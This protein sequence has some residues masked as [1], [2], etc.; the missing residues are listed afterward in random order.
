MYIYMSVERERTM[1]RC[2]ATASKQRINSLVASQVTATLTGTKG[3]SLVV[4][5]SS[6]CTSSK[7]DDK[8]DGVTTTPKTTTNQKKKKEDPSDN[9]KNLLKNFEQ[10][11]DT[12][13]EDQQTTKD[14][15]QQ[16]QQS[17]SSSKEQQLQKTSDKPSLKKISN[18]P[19]FDASFASYNGGGLGMYMAE[20]EADE[21]TAADEEFDI[22][23]FK[24]MRFNEHED[25]IIEDVEDED[26]MIEDYELD[27]DDYGGDIVDDLL[28]ESQAI[29]YE[30]DGEDG[31]GVKLSKGDEADLDEDAD[32]DQDEEFIDEYEED[33]DELDDELLDDADNDGDLIGEE[34]LDKELDKLLSKKDQEFAMAEFDNIQEEE[35]DEPQAEF[36]MQDMDEA[37]EL[38]VERATEDDDEDV[39][40]PQDIAEYLDLE[41]LDRQ[42]LFTHTE[43]LELFMKNFDGE[44]GILETLENEL[45]QDGKQEVDEI[46]QD[47]DDEDDMIQVEEEIDLEEIEEDEE[48]EG[49]EMDDDLEEFDE[50]G[51]EEV[52][53]DNLSDEETDLAVRAESLIKDLPTLPFHEE[54]AIAQ[55]EGLTPFDQR[56]ADYGKLTKDKMRVFTKNWEQGLLQDSLETLFADDMAQLA[57]TQDP[58][59]VP[60]IFDPK[61]IKEYNDDVNEKLGDQF[62]EHHQRLELVQELIDA[63]PEDSPTI[64][65]Y[66]KLEQHQDQDQIALPESAKQKAKLKALLTKYSVEETKAIVQDNIAGNDALDAGLITPQ[67]YLVQPKSQQEINFYNLNTIESTAFE[68][69]AAD[70][71]KVV[72]AVGGVVGGAV[73]GVV[74]T[75]ATEMFV[76][77]SDVI[78]KEDDAKWDA[79]LEAQIVDAMDQTIAQDYKQQEAQEL[80]DQEEHDKYNEI[81]KE[82]TDYEPPNITVDSIFQLSEDNEFYNSPS[83]VKDFG[84][85]EPHTY[86]EM[87]VA[88]VDAHTSQMGIEKDDEEDDEFHDPNAIINTKY[89]YLKKMDLYE[90]E[91]KRDVEN[92]EMQVYDQSAVQADME[93]LT[94]QLDLVISQDIDNIVEEK[95]TP[96][97]VLAA[98]KLGKAKDFEIN[99]NE[100]SSG[101]IEITEENIEQLLAQA[102][103]WNNTSDIDQI[104]REL[105]QEVAGQDEDDDGLYHEP[106]IDEMIPSAEQDVE[107]EMNG[108]QQLVEE[109]EKELEDALSQELEKITGEID[110]QNGVSSSS[111]ENNNGIEK[112]DDSADI[113]AKNSDILFNKRFLEDGEE[114]EPEL[115][116]ELEADFEKEPLFDNDFGDENQPLH[117]ED[118]PT[119]ADVPSL[120]Q[121]LFKDQQDA[122]RE[123]KQSGDAPVVG[124]VD[125]EQ[126]IEGLDLSKIEQTGALS[127][128]DQEVMFSRFIKSVQDEID[129]NFEEFAKQEI[130]NEIDLL[131]AQTAEDIV[132]YDEQGNAI[133]QQTESDDAAAENFNISDE[134]FSELVNDYGSM[135]RTELGVENMELPFEIIEVNNPDLDVYEAMD[136]MDPS[137]FNKLELGLNIT[138]PKGFL[139]IGEYVEMIN[140]QEDMEELNEPMAVLT[141]EADMYL[142]RK[143]K[144]MKVLAKRRERAQKSREA[145]LAKHREAIAN[146]TATPT[147]HIKGKRAMIPTAAAASNTIYVSPYE[148]NTYVK[149]ADM[150]EQSEHDQDI[151]RDILQ[152][153]HVSLTLNP[154]HN[155][156][157]TKSS[158]KY[159]QDQLTS[160]K[161][162]AASRLEQRK[163][164]VPFDDPLFKKTDLLIEPWDLERYDAD[165]YGENEDDS[166]DLDN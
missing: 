98:L 145:Q 89:E 44:E 62:L 32:D 103:D 16:P 33:D 94:E 52:D 7:K 105:G 70:G 54:L 76:P 74:T 148:P 65:D 161:A 112:S 61:L 106:T 86:A 9:Y 38:E 55:E 60:Y 49:L 142:R 129:N 11:L 40:V 153:S 5:K 116:D 3:G 138:S 15:Q 102:N 100:E 139:E 28:E 165:Y 30:E 113:D 64:E 63:D 146:S 93:R 149:L 1:Y 144:K 56:S 78:S 110:E 154:F 135:A 58:S 23:E 24:N 4:S 119:V 80:F 121:L 155:H 90:Q 20:Q 17:S 22:E 66:I 97:Q 117:V 29:E 26:I 48:D 87:R 143:E 12:K 99:E 122:L 114:A 27:R 88:L 19:A 59:K 133:P 21:D 164:A 131:D 2:A 166:V 18:I 130:Q 158:M 123:A 151:F 157:Q 111:G 150:K 73:G 91:Y 162:H 85:R 50:D 96:A 31:D 156:A 115:I 128:Q 120:Q 160:Y 75:A 53:Y 84:V 137:D 35:D 46:D 159:I 108:K 71:K 141:L 25:V 36:E 43:N 45:R 6:Y 39:V 126:F 82:G 13:K 140:D 47:D 107:E 163:N 147:Q 134:E 69:V 57:S 101:A 124:S 51:E 127:A 125:I 8:P 132:L 41:D 67:E 136:K 37:A 14:Q 10:R 77:T 104:V 81:L 83:L 42:N 68:T 34:L 152:Q 72:G 118:I 109:E 79:Q 95:V 92:Q